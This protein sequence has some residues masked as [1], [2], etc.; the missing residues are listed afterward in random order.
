MAPR[1]PSYRLRRPTG[2]VVV[3]L[4]GRA[5]YLGRHSNAESHAGPGKMTAGRTRFVAVTRPA[6][7]TRTVVQDGA[8]GIPLMGRLH[9][10]VKRLKLVWGDAYF[11]A[12]L[13]L[14]WV[15]GTW[16]GVM[17]QPKQRIEEQTFGWLGD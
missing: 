16:V 8:R 17:V 10:S 15:M 12:S 4:A 2:R 14:G 6:W 1:I 7:S 5:L 3:T 9:P 11:D 13:T